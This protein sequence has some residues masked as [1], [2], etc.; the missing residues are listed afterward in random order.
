MRILACA[1]CNRWLVLEIDDTD[2]AAT[3][4]P[5]EPDPDPVFLGMVVWSASDAEQNRV[6]RCPPCAR[7]Q[8][9]PADS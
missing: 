7:A 3:D 5:H 8:H 2:P 4:W 1:D 6:A 9:P